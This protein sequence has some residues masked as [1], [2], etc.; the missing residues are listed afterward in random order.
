MID[1]KLMQWLFHSPTSGRL[2]NFIC[3]VINLRMSNDIRLPVSHL[4]WHSSIPTFQFW[5]P[6]VT[7]PLPPSFISIIKGISPRQWTSKQIFYPFFQT[8]HDFYP[9][10]SQGILSE[11]LVAHII[12]LWFRLLWS[13]EWETLRY[14]NHQLQWSPCYFANNVF[15]P[16]QG[17]Q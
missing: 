4:A 1:P 12:S 10:F 16:M 6:V 2:R 8:V 14:D 7:L 3:T 15:I 11:K 13:S 9:T 17:C 5:N